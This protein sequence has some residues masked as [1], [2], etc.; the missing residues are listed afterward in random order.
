M[1]LKIF[2]IIIF[3]NYNNYYFYNFLR[4]T[5]FLVPDNIDILITT[6]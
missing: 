2:T 4:E 5:C 6:D 1:S 3:L